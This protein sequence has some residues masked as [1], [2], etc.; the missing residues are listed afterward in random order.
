MTRFLADR[1]SMGLDADGTRA[2]VE[3]FGTALVHGLGGALL[4]DTG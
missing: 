1:D 3:D 4:N 2:N